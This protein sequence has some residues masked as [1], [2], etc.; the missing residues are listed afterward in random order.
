MEQRFRQTREFVNYYLRLGVPLMSPIVYCHQFATEFAAPT[1]ALSWAPLNEELLGRS[2][3]MWI[4][5]L[6][7]WKSSLGIQMESQMAKRLGIPQKFKEPLPY[8]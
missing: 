8:A 4:L 2:S 3:E 7:G 6:A 5:R 1:D